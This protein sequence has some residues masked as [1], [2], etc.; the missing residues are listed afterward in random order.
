[1]RIR[2]EACGVCHSDTLAVEGFFP[3][4]EF[5]RVP[6]HEAIGRIDALG[7]GVM[8]WKVGQRVGVGYLGGNCGWCA[9]CRRGLFVHCLHQQITGTTTDGGYAQVMYAAAS[10]LSAVP[11]ALASVDAAPLVCAGLTTYN[12]LRRSVARAGDLVAVQGVGGL[13]HLALQ[14]ARHMGFRVAAI[15][16]GRSKEELAVR[17]GA[18]HYIDSE[19]ADPAKALQQL[20]GA[21]LILATAS[22]SKSQEG[23]IGGL[24][25]GGSL[26]V[27]GLDGTPIAIGSM[28]LVLGARSVDGSLTG[29]AQDG[30]DTLNFSVLQNIRSMNE[31]MPLEEAAAGYAR[32]VSNK[33]R[34]RVVLT[35]GPS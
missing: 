25:P 19:A 20:G 8:G 12:A 6:G 30:E 24:R 4:A 33:A 32:M 7:A 11:D 31:V 22:S 23:L 28:D 3:N 35:M 13:G 14:F 26:L 18:H 34:F 10:G 9:E 5:P 16:R 2:V 15:A 17:L 29:S 27:V 21:T 1:M